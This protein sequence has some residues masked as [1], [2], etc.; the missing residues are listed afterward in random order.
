MPDKILTT[1]ALTAALDARRARGERIV[2]T[3][4]CFDLLHVGHTRYLQE[5]KKLGDCLV[6]GLNS[7]ASI[8]TIK[9]PGRPLVPHAQ[10][11]EVLAASACV[12]P[13]VLSALAGRLADR[14]TSLLVVTPTD[15]AAERLQADVAF[16]HRLQGAAPDD[17]LWFPDWGVLPYASA[18]P[19][20]V[21]GQRMRVLD[22]LRGADRGLTLIVPVTAFLQRLL[23]RSLF[24]EAC[25]SL[26]Q[27]DTIERARLVTRLLRLGYRRASVVENPA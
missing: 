25:F 19:V 5:A 9:P 17:I 27:T 7:D 2:F 26:K 24:A 23:P 15:E 16:S 11:A 8:R 18:P 12:D 6:V 3:N 20:E 10:R 14:K 22:R 13:A 4:G 1:K 21:I